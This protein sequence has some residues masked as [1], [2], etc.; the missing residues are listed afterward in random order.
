MKII[1]FA[2]AVTAA[3]VRDDESGVVTTRSR[4]LVMIVVAD[5]KASN[6]YIR[7]IIENAL[8]EP[9]SGGHC[10]A[11]EHI[12][13]ID[14]TVLHVIRAEVVSDWFNKNADVEVFSLA[15]DDEITF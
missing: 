10:V 12:E 11:E 9:K 8:T 3:P 14:L 5:H 6:A 4:S 13:R 7:D 1:Y 2:N 15:Y